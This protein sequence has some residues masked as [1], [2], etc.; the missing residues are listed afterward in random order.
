MKLPIKIK[1]KSPKLLS[2]DKENVIIKPY[3][4]Y[5]KQWAMRA[6]IQLKTDERFFLIQQFQKTLAPDKKLTAYYYDRMNVIFLSYAKII[7]CSR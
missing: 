6:G 3:K 2:K 7:G 4:K 5:N 1:E